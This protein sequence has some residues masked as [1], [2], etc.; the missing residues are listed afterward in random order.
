VHPRT[1]SDP[2]TSD[3]VNGLDAYHARTRSRGV[4]PWVYWPVRAVLQ[5]LLTLWFRLA[6]L[7]R[8]NVPGEGAV[9]LASNHRSFLDPFVIGCCVKRPVYFVAKQELFEN[10]LIGWLLNSL[11]AF[12]VR[13]GQSD[14]DSVE[15]SMELLARGEIVVIFPEGTRIR[16]GSLGSPKRGVGRMA[17]ESGAAVVPVAVTG[18]ERS[19]RGWIVRPVKVKVRLGRPLTFPR[20]DEASP[21]LATEVTERI[22]PC[23]ELQ[24]E[25]LGGLPP[26]RKAAIVG[27]GAMGTG[28][29][30]LLARAGLEVRLGCRTRAQAEEIG[31]ARANEDRLPGVALPDG[32]TTLALADIEFAGVDLVVFAVPTQSLPLAVAEVGADVGE[33][34]AVL[35]A[36]KGLVPPLG[37]APTLYV[38]ERVRARAV[39][40][41]GGPAHAEEAVNSGASVL[42]ASADPDF[43]RQLGDVLERAGLDVERTDDVVGT[44]LAGCAKNTAVLAAAAAA[45][46]SG[47][48]A[49]G[50]AA[51]RVFMEI[52]ELAVR[53][54][55]RS[56]TFIGLAGTGDLVG[57]AMASHSRSRRA[58]ELLGQGLPADQ[59]RAVLGSA[60][61][62]LDS[63]PYLAD[64]LARSGIQAPATRALSD[65]VEG[66][67]DAAAWIETVRSHPDRA[68]RAA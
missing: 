14:P 38:S 62:A 4:R 64:A 39:A 7:G 56:E 17:L 48:N 32:V 59:I 44:E 61:E 47:E 31:K 19:R 22:W 36:A 26:L 10:R 5:P 51:A 49:A 68:R 2:P 50:A 25:W 9:I 11:G 21:N 40:C 16:S 15:T 60:P 67:V 58:G 63:T 57:T 54:G 18:S 41:L 24:W 13:R 1:T 33:R 65:L 8:A 20:L 23:V 66:R 34:S 35:V 28:L 29:A 43:R 12:P 3:R 53:S 52:H 30:A 6:R 55:G 46:G 27:A 37:T 45:A 42:L